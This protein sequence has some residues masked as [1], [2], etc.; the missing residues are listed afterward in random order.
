MNLV[1]GLKPFIRVLVQRAKLAEEHSNMVNYQMTIVHQSQAGGQTFGRRNPHS[2][3]WKEIRT[4]DELHI[5][6][7]ALKS[8][9]MTLGRKNAHFDLLRLKNHPCCFDVQRDCGFGSY[10]CLSHPIKEI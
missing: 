10:E 8:I 3:H 2:M 7:C 1:G 6:S 5:L 4:K 9:T